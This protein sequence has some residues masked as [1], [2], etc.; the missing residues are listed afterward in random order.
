MEREWRTKAVLVQSL[1]VIAVAELA[2]AQVATP[3]SEP[4][5]LHGETLDGKTIVLPDA[6]AGKVT[7]L[8]FGASKKGGEQTGPWK[9]H[10]AADFGSNPQTSYYVAALLQS[11][12]SVFRGVIRSGMRS[13]TPDAARP[14]VLTSASDEAAWKKYLNITDDSLPSVLL[15]DETG[16]RLLGYNGTFDP[17]RYKALKTAADAALQHH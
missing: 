14:H 13:G 8:V 12:P 6:A 4:P 2:L 10:F 1:V 9:D 16:H 15:L 17:D 5:K 11:V 3:R 7:L